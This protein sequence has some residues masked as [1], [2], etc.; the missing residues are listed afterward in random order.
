MEIGTLI[1][2]FDA[3]WSP[4]TFSVLVGLAA[5]MAW[6]A[7]APA[8]PRR[9]VTSRLDDYLDRGDI[10]VEEDLRQPFFRRTIWPAV[11]SLLHFLGR[12]LP[13]KNLEATRQ[14]LQQAGNPGGLSALDF[15]GVRVLVI[16]A[17]GGLFFFLAGRNQ[18]L[19]IALR[20]AALGLVLAFLLPVYWLRTRVRTRKHKILRALPDALDMLT[21]G[22]EAG[23]AFESA[24]VRVGEKWDNPLTREF[25]RTVAEMRVGMSREDALTRMSERCGVPELSSFVA[26]LVQS[27]QLGVSIAQVL[28]TQAEE[29]RLK[30]R[31]RA[32]ELARQAGVKMILP[33]AL[34]ILPALF[35]V[36]LGPI[37]PQF[38]EIMQ[39]VGG[40]APSGGL[41]P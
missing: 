5:L 33:L 26:I 15:Y 9:D 12:L 37:I 41:V 10:V 19:S 28:H 13:K 38:V 6:T 35:V 21:I 2:Q 11:R 27:S 1:G 4:L 14:K 34:F 23:L 25:K 32:E 17:L 31:Q 39:T 40:G 3:L 30:R 16:L 8:A 20:N 29:M 36:I 7:F 24:M 18:P 22:V